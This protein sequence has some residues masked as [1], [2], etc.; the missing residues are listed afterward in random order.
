MSCNIYEYL[1]EL[2][3]KKDEVSSIGKEIESKRREYEEILGQLSE[4]F[5]TKRNEVAALN[6]TIVSVRLG[7]LIHELSWL[8][9]VSVNHV[10]ASMKFNIDFSN[11]DE[12]FKFIDEVK[13][14]DMS[15]FHNNVRLR[16]WSDL[17][18]LDDS[19][20]PFDYFTFLPFNMNMV[21]SDGKKLID[22]CSFKIEPY[23]NG[24]LLV[25]FSVE[26]DIQD[27]VC[28]FNLRYFE[29]KDNTSWYPGDLFTQAIINCSQREYN[30]KADKIRE[31]IR[32]K[33]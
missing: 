20:V 2:K 13:D 14:N 18:N 26:K 22:R 6:E 29:M 17:E 15:Y 11:I 31:R 9:G 16:L 23:F 30:I 3:E 33:K 25:E 32:N 7:D 28:N 27:I 12:V 10:C 8:S 24:K 1:G 5:N 4:R 19:F 21:Q